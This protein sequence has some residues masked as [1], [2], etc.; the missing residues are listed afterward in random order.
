M[1][2]SADVTGNVITM[3]IRHAPTTAGTHAMATHPSAYVPL[4]CE[5]HDLLE[6]LATTR[7]LAQIRFRDTEGLVQH[8]SA[9]ITDV[10]ARAGAEYLSL[11]SGETLRLDQLV[12]V[13]NE[14]LTDQ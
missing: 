11:G 8:R 10:Y 4:S 2:S 12:E 1:I 14:R 6:T 13:D 5:F 3:A 9:T 7:Q